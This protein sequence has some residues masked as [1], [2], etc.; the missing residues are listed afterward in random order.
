MASIE[1]GSVE[2]SSMSATTAISA[3][4]RAMSSKGS[5]SE[6]IYAMVARVVNGLDVTGGDL[7]D[8]GCGRGLLWSNVRDRFATYTGVDILPFEGFPEEGRF[9]TADLDAGT[10]ALPDASFDVVAAVETIEHLDGPRRF[11]KDLVRLIRP[12]GWLI[13]TTPNQLSAHS[14]LS[15]LLRGYFSAFAEAPGLYPAHLTALVEA[16]LLRM[17]RELGLTDARIHYSNRGRI[18]LTPW[19]WPLPLRG[20]RFSDN[21]LLVSRRP[22][23]ETGPA[24]ASR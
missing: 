6:A 23:H 12:A 9:V 10:I 21:L 7:L 8:V 14:L 2:I 11:V 15:L 3:A 4:H 13:V 16:D 17:A 24:P 22:G 1:E 20:R 19:H 18:P 5:S